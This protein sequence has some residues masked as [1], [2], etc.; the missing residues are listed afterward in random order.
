MDPNRLGSSVW[1][2]EAVERRLREQACWPTRATGSERF[3]MASDVV[4]VADPLH[5]TG[6][7]RARVISIR[8][9]LQCGRTELVVDAGAK[10]TL[11][12]S[13]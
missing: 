12:Y 5:S 6:S 4:V 11:S 1:F 7:W 10:V 2:I 13:S 3:A 8:C 9:S